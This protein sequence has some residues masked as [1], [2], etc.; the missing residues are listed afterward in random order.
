MTFVKV[1]RI[2]AGI[3][4]DLGRFFYL[5][6]GGFKKRNPTCCGIKMVKKVLNGNE[7]ADEPAHLP[8]S[9][10]LRVAN[11]HN[12]QPNRFDDNEILPLVK[13]N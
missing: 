8:D 2:P 13:L 6:K 11:S 12:I 5:A 4:R 1:L 10:T 3:L 7:N 9:N